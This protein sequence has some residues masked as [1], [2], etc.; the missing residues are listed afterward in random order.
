MKAKAIKHYD[1]MIKF[2]KSEIDEGGKTVNADRMRQSIR[3]DWYAGSCPYCKKYMIHHEC[4]S[5]TLCIKCPLMPTGKT[6]DCCNGLWMEM[7][8]ASTWKE[9]IVCAERVKE[10]IRENG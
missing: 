2:A 1:R 9:F 4:L 10:Y 3:E 6:D 8:K 7:S 5:G